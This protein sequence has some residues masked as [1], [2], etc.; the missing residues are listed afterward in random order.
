M[1]VKLLLKDI[2]GKF[3]QPL[4]FPHIAFLTACIRKAEVEDADHV[5]CFQVIVSLFS[6]GS[7]L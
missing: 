7:L 1:K 5:D 3:V 4:Y 2:Q 6:F